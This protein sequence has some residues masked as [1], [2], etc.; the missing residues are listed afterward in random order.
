MTLTSRDI[1]SLNGPI[2]LGTIGEGKDYLFYRDETGEGLF[3]DPA[4][5]HLRKQIAKDFNSRMF[6]TAKTRINIKSTPRVDFQYEEGKTSYTINDMKTGLLIKLKDIQAMENI[7]RGE[8][9]LYSANLSYKH[10]NDNVS[11]QPRRVAF[12]LYT[13]IEFIDTIHEEEMLGKFFS[14][15]SVQ[16]DRN[17]RHVTYLGNLHKSG[18]VT[19]TKKVAEGIKRLNKKID[20]NAISPTVKVSTPQPRMVQESQDSEIPT[21]TER[22]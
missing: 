5:Y 21:D 1:R 17:Q 9:L 2:Y 4:N 14:K 8:N 20:R 6:E 13:A 22:Q 3:L 10:V 19:R 15:S 12:E 18:D 11:T 7:E 16:L